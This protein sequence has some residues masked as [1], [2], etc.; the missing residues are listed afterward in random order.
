[1][2]T[3]LKIFSTAI[4][5]RL[6]IKRYMLLFICLIDFVII[7]LRLLVIKKYQTALFHIKLF[8]FRPISGMQWVALG[9]LVMAG[10]SNR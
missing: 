9:L 4:L 5:Y 6:I 8:L 10:I 7:L 2:L 1:M 3:N